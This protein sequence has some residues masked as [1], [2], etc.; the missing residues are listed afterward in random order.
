MMCDG[1]LWLSC[2]NTQLSQLSQAGGTDS[3]FG[4]GGITGLYLG[5]FL[6]DHVGCRRMFLLQAAASLLVLLLFLIFELCPYLYRYHYLGRGRPRGV[7]GM[8]EPLMV[9]VVEESN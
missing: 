1:T 4:V 7:E 2:C 6:Y 9:N 8:Q 3:F 5:G